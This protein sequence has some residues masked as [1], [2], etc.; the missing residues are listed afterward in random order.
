VILKVGASQNWW[1][2]YFSRGKVVKKSTKT[3]NKRAA[4]E[5]AKKFYEDILV[6]ERR[7]LPI[8]DNPTFERV[9]DQLIAEQQ[10][11]MER[12]QRNAKLNLNDSQK[13]RKD[14]L[15]F[16]GHRQIRDITYGLIN[17][18]L[19]K[20]NERKLK[21]ATVKLHLNLI[22][23]ILKLAQRDGLLDRIP[24][25]PTVRT[26]D[27]PRGW[28]SQEQYELLRKAATDL[29]NEG[30]VVKHRKV[31]NE[32]RHLITFMV[33]TFLRP[34]DIKTLRHRNIEVVEGDH[35]YLRIQTIAE[36]PQVINA[37]IVSMEAAVAVYR[38]LMKFHE[39]AGLGNDPD[40]RNRQT[41][42]EKMRHQFNAILDRVDLKT[43]A[44]GEPR[45]IYSL[46]HTAIMF[47][48]TLGEGIDLLTLARN[49]RTSVDMIERFYGKHLKAEMNVG[50]IQSLRPRVTPN[51]K[52]TTAKG[53][54]AKTASATS[55]PQTES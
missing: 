40:I 33:N 51:S 30:A 31:T 43:A 26:V 35:T 44:T 24:S 19:K 42:M 27:S 18:Y 32:M 7:L 39:T 29:A 28:F 49:A 48:L 15:P 2:R 52:R 54:T 20:L 45:T 23:K 11:L 5:F 36:D 46:R 8:A 41:A 25:M 17:D 4:I 38:S 10:A 22:H 13:L 14:M 47:R 9:A 16:F 3:T 53:P 55:T 34:S 1:A 12:N 6:R 50:M 21:P 37:P